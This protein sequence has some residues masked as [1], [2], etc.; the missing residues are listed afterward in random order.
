M[1]Q[2]PV[3]IPEPREQIRRKW[4]PCGR[5]SKG[6]EAEREKSCWDQ[7]EAR[8]TGAAAPG[9][10]GLSFTGG[11]TRGGEFLGHWRVTLFVSVSHQLHFKP[12]NGRD[13]VFSF[14]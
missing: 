4:V 1:V 7:Q 12:F 8:C 13:L 2:G 14:L 6:P 10:R 3:N 5:N 9:T 11:V